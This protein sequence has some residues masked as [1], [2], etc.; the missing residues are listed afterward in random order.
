MVKGLYT[1][2]KSNLQFDFRYMGPSPRKRAGS[3]LS[4]QRY[5]SS[6]SWCQTF[7]AP[8]IAPNVNIALQYLSPSHPVLFEF[9]TIDFG[10]QAL[11]DYF[12]FTTRLELFLC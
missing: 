10:V 3:A 11:G 9:K 12:H 5:L 1:Q 4:R 6:S 7:M 8:P 2:H